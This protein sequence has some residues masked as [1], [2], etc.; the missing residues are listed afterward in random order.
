MFNFYTNI[1]A[2][3]SPFISFWWYVMP[4]LLRFSFF[5]VINYILYQTDSHVH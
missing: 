4:V 1:F 5:L 3:F 2:F